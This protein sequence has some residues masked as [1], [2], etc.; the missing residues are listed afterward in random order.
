MEKA[1]FSQLREG[2]LGEVLNARGNSGRV[3][4]GAVGPS[5][6]D[7]A[8]FP[9]LTTSWDR[10]RQDLTS[11]APTALIVTGRHF[12]VPRMSK[13][14]RS[15][16]WMRVLQLRLVH[17]VKPI[18]WELLAPHIARG[19]DCID[20]AKSAE[21]TMLNLFLDADPDLPCF[22]GLQAKRA[23]PDA[24]QSE[25]VFA[26]ALLFVQVNGLVD[27]VCGQ[28][29]A[30]PASED[31]CTEVADFNLALQTLLAAM[32]CLR[33]GGNA[34]FVLR[35]TLLRSTVGLICCA[36]LC[37]ESATLIAEMRLAPYK[38]LVCHGFLN[39]G[40]AAVVELLEAA[41]SRQNELCESRQ[42]QRVCEIV[43]VQ[44]IVNSSL[45]DTMQRCNEWVLSKEI[46]ADAE[47]QSCARSKRQ[48]QSA[49]TQN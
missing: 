5:S 20:D 23:R 1:G 7:V 25:D 29:C 27:A 13:F 46:D 22:K 34:V 2:D 47:T 24:F 8:P 37:F 4:L 38:V 15:D 43:P 17:G 14:C 48:M 6:A 30:Q 11:N 10:I 12:Q 26:A 21:P 40:Q 41:R 28:W 49:V 36:S 3:G 45:L 42:G 33:P 16:S 32:K 19:C 18:V 35:D 9:L 44:G 31:R 39:P